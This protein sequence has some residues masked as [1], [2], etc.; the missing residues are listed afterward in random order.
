[1]RQL[2]TQEIQSVN[3]AGLL[4]SVLVSTV[5]TGAQAGAAAG[6]GLLAAGQGLASAGAIIAKPLVTGTVNLLKFLI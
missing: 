5:Q 3:G 6:Q 4:T 2:H 1:M